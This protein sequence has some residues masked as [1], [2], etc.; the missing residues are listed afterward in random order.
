MKKIILFSNNLHINISLK[1]IIEEAGYAYAFCQTIDEVLLSVH[2]DPPHAILLDSI[3]MHA[4]SVTVEAGIRADEAT[5]HI[6]CLYLAEKIEKFIFHPFEKEIV[7]SRLERMIGK[8][9]DSLEKEILIIEDDRDIA[10]ILSINLRGKGFRVR[11]A[12]DGEQGVAEVEKQ[13]P[14]LIILDLGLPKLP[15]KEV[16]KTIR[17]NELTEHIPIIMLTAKTEEVDRIIGKIV[18]ANLYMTKPFEID[19]VIVQVKAILNAQ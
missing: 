6:P 7:I 8:A 11:V 2:Q 16:C 3:S 15:G 9:D 5:A 10:Q 19:E 17:E 18:G 12:H 14:D 4:E 1:S 13:K